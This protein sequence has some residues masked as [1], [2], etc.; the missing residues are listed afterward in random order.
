MTRAWK[1]GTS[2]TAEAAVRVIANVLRMELFP[3]WQYAT[4]PAGRL[5]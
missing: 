2:G 4:T 3:S 5:G 1:T